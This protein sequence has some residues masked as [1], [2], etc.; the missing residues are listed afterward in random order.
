VKRGI[1][2]RIMPPRCATAAVLASVA[3]S[4]CVIVPVTVENYDADCG[5]V[6][7]HMELQ[8]VQVGAISSCANQSCAALVIAAAGVTAASAIISG[9]I[10]VVG[11]AAYWA[12][13]RVDCL[14][15]RP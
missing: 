5:V 7:H 12:E 15:P 3:M 9:S 4:A 6:T 11:N 2:W 13:R 1:L 14:A 10:V 8:A